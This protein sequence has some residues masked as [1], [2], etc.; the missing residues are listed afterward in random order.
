MPLL[1]LLAFGHMVID[2]NGGCI[3]AL[4]PF[5]KTALSLTYTSSA[6][7]ILMSNITSSLIQPLFGYF[8]DKTARRWLLPAA[9]FVSA[10]GIALTGL[11]ASYAL[12]LLLVVLSGFGIASYHPEGYR[13]ATQV[14]GERKVTG[15]SIFSTGG[16]LGIAL[17]PPV[18]TA[19]VTAFGLT[20]TL[21]LMIPG[22][23]AA[24]LLAAA[25]PRFTPS[26]ALHSSSESAHPQ[27]T[28]AYGMGILIV[29]VAIRAWTQTGF[30]TLVPFYYLDVLKGDPRMVGT[31]LAVFLGSG[32]VGTL[33][34]GP[35]ADR[36]GVRRYAVG[37][38]LLATPLAVA[39]LFAHGIFIYLALGALGFVLISTFSVMVVLAQSYMPRNL[40][41]ASGLIVGFATGAGGIGATVLGAVADHYSLTR[42]LMIAAILPLVAF[43]VSIFLPER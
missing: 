18:I 21:G 17:G 16:N 35:I 27:K 23:V 9:V 4:L 7:V 28:S 3:P 29:V 2:I 1:G 19:L 30:S 39:F 24:V 31:L 37:V 42:A 10:L 8:A 32:A 43:A 11:T 38:F 13:T 20:G 41:M 22:V 26:G 40:G 25:L 36:F 34:A 12:V 14:A 6:V 5:L 33:C 15:V